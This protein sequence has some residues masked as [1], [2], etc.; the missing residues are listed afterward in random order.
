MQALTLKHRSGCGGFI[1]T[2]TLLSAMVS[3]IVLMS[4]CRTELDAVAAGPVQC[5]SMISLQ[6]FDEQ[7]G[8]ASD[9]AGAATDAASRPTLAGQPLLRLSALGNGTGTPLSDR[10]SAWNTTLLP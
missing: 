6:P 10:S 8:A 5:R 9:D 7:F 2:G 4:G 3:A 1:T